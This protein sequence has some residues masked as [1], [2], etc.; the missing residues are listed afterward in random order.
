MFENLLSKRNHQ[1]R[2]A[3]LLVIDDA[4]LTI[5]EQPDTDPLQLLTILVAALRPR[6]CADIEDAIQRWQHMNQLLAATPDYRYSL[7]RMI[8]RLLASRHQVRFY[9]E[10][11]LLPNSGFFSELNR[12]LVHKLLPE[13]IDNSDLRSCIGLVFSRSDD[14]VWITAIPA[15]DRR[16]F[17]GLLE[18]H[19]T[20]D[21]ESLQIIIEQMIESL[22]VLSHRICAMGLEPE[23]LRAYPRLRDNESPF[24]AMNIELID[25]INSFRR[26]LNGETD[27]DDGSHLLVLLQQC[28]E[29][30]KKTHHSSL[31][32]G[33][34][35][36]LSFLL[37]RLSQH[38]ERL[39]LLIG[40]LTV[41]FRPDAP[42]ELVQCWTEFLSDALAGERKHN[43]ISEHFS[44]LLSMMALRVTDNAAHTG[45][46]YIANTAQEWR[47]ML[48]K[49]AGAGIFIAVLAL[50]KILSIN[51][52]LGATTQ[53]WLNALLYAGGFSIIYMLHFVIA[54][55]QPAMTAATLAGSIS[56]TRGRLRELEKIVDLIRDTFRSQLAAI[57][58]NIGIALP[59]A[60]VV[61]IALDAYSGTHIVKAEKAMRLLEDLSPLRSMALFHAAIAGVW[62]FVTGLVS[63]YLDNRAAYSQT[64]IRI[65]QLRW[66]RA[67]A[68]TRGANAIGEY[69]SNHAGGLGGNIFFGLM[70][71]L[72]PL[73]GT[74]LGLPLDIRHI[75]FSSANLGYAIAALDFDV[76]LPLLLSS[77]CGV[78]LV[79]LVNL[80][81]SFTL[82][83][84]VA[85]RSRRV[86]M[87]TLVPVIPRLW[88]RLRQ[89]P[90]SFL[91]PAIEE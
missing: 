88:H 36:P 18:I 17:W 78:L 42:E 61:S 83:L 77:S 67:F 33:T 66:L 71:G 55:K 54:T 80:G 7:R 49:A 52:H 58:G 24:I 43:S 72:T 87:H 30:V 21:V 84:W 40:V 16:N 1:D 69:L 20:D 37:E 76:P 45:E 4:L 82:A 63:G 56:Q 27:C 34:S 79:G 28:V 26:G 23:L 5:H 47:D 19:A 41:R 6:K 12:K 11:G 86:S 10:S 90:E 50:L 53:A 68:G 75:A 2:D 70:L 9:T 3:E 64:G 73:F 22:L 32:L 46:H 13:P 59:L 81:V 38:L 91:L 39:R 44:N 29:T 57:V 48:F 65:A 89:Q 51:L 35:M 15:E 74:I 14:D 62:L 60:V 8:V 85:M 31:R 25:F